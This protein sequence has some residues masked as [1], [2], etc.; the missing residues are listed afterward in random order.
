M[1]FEVWSDDPVECRAVSQYVVV[2]VVL[3]LRVRRPWERSLAHAALVVRVTPTT[4]L[5]FLH[6]TWHGT[7]GT[8]SMLADLDLEFFRSQKNDALPPAA[9]ARRPTP[10]N[11]RSKPSPM[12]RLVENPSACAPPPAAVPVVESARGLRKADEAAEAEEEKAELVKC[13]A[14]SEEDKDEDDDDD[15]G[16]DEEDWSESEEE[17]EEEWTVADMYEAAE[18]ARRK[19]EAA[20]AAAGASVELTDAEKAINE[21]AERAFVAQSLERAK[22]AREAEEAMMEQRHVRA[23]V[24]GS[25]VHV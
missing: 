19:A 17:E 15:G 5:C 7:D 3:R 2:V 8:L 11:A 16:S 22:A 6:V 12:L 25:T 1:E 23:H 21:A 20:A 24:G 13:V 18:S 4:S 14:N 9:A 10:V